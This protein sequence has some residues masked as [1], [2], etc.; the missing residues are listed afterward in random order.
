MANIPTST[1]PTPV[2]IDKFLGLNLSSTGD[3]QI[4][5]GESGNMNNFYITNDNKLRKMYGYKTF[6]DFNKEVIG[7]YAAVLNKIH[8]L[9]VA[10]KDTDTKT[11]KKQT[12]KQ[13]LPLKHHFLP[14]QMRSFCLKMM[15]KFK[16][17]LVCLIQH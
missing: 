3:T 6:Y 16:R 7:M 17:N 12:D 13:I 9:L 2:T 5:L 15:K 14:L 1:A 4:K 10:V 8:Y 11:P